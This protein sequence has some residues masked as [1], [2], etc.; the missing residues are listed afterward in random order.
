MQLLL[1]MLMVPLVVLVLLLLLM[2]LALL[3]RL[4]FLLLPDLSPLRCAG[5][6]VDGSPPAP[7]HP[8]RR[9]MAC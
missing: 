2:L 3:L 8:R 5:L 4:L 6:R 9:P 7:R 1:R